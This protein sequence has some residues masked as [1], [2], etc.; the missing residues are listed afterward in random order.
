MTANATARDRGGDSRVRTDTDSA[1]SRGAKSG[2]RCLLY[3]NSDAHPAHRVFADAV[4]AD[5]RHFETGVR[6]S[7]S[8]GNTERI[9]DRIRTGGT[10]PAYDTVIAEGSAPLQTGLAYKLRRPDATLVY[11]AADET[12][13]TLSERPTR[14]LWRGLEPIS[15]RLLDGVIAVGRDVYDWARPYLGDHPVAYVRPPISDAKYGRLASLSPTSPQEPFT[16]LSAGEAKP[17]NGYDRL[18]RAVGRFARTVD[19]DVRLVVLGEGHEAEGYADRSRVLTPGFVD[20][21]TFA[22]WFGRASVYVQ[23]SRGDA[24]PV[25]ALEGILSGTPTVVTEATGVREL[26]PPRQVVPP[27]ETGLLEG[28][29]DVFE[30]AP[31]ERRSA[32]SEQ[33]DLVADLTESNQGDRFSAALEEF[34]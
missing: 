18:A 10:L 2:D 23:S 31:D 19:A 9:V 14:Y 15:R 24:F 6:P 12:F 20:L 25:A 22:D 17:A 5:R 26:L 1:Q 3:Q 34:A 32:A 7:E 28:L 16:I 29:R 33:R 27:T 4:G 30:R 8:N 13:Y 21:D 11:L